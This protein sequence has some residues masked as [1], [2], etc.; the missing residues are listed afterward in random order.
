MRAHDAATTHF[1]ARKRGR[2]EVKFCAC[3]AAE[4]SLRAAREFAATGSGRPYFLV[5]GM[6]K[7]CRLP[8]GIL[9]PAWRYPVQFL[10]LCRFRIARTATHRKDRKTTGK[11]GAR[12]LRDAPAANAALRTI[13]EA[14]ARMQGHER[15]S[16]PG[17]VQ[18]AVTVAGI[19]Q[20]AVPCPAANDRSA[21]GVAP[22]SFL[23]QSWQCG[24]RCAGRFGP[25][26]AVSIQGKRSARIWLYIRL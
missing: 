9:S 13:P 1:P 23:M 24:S 20:P 18:R 4:I 8:V 17:S 15:R 5:G 16:W 11:T 3:I 21:A 22:F 14:A 19:A 26:P 12:R 6:H 2:S 10:S 25:V 7:R